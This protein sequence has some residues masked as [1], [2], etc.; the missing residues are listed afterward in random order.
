MIGTSKY[1]APEVMKGDEYGKMADIWSLGV[2]LYELWTG[3]KAYKGMSETEV[4]DAV[5]VG[6]ARPGAKG[7]MKELL[8]VE[9]WLRRLIERC[10]GQQLQ[11]VSAAEFL[12][13]F[14]RSH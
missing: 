6:Q 12:K 3:E 4:E 14:S 9:P 2:T 13:E 10:F 7:F 1:M 8:P 5:S 11:R